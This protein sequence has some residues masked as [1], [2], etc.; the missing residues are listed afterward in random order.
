MDPGDATERIIGAALEVHR[1]LGPGLLE[2]AF[3][4]CLALEM[5]RRK[6]VFRREAQLP[7]TYKGIR[8]ERGYR[9]D[10]QVE[11]VVIA[12]LRVVE[13]LLPL[14]DNQLRTQLRLSGAEVGLLLNFHAPDLTRA[15]RRM[16]TR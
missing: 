5:S 4:E 9:A 3:R 6:I 13:L 16:S 15:I 2:S 14:H 8:L 11:E 7:V 10:F 1:T 12:R